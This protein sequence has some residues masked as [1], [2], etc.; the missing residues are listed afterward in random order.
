MFEKS[1]SKI[2]TSDSFFCT[3]IVRGYK[4]LWVFMTFFKIRIQNPSD[5]I[6]FL[7]FPVLRKKYLRSIENRIQF[8][9]R[10]TSKKTILFINH[11]E[12]RTGAPKLLFEIAKF[13]E[14]EYRVI[15]LSLRQG[16]AHEVFKNSF[17][18]IV[19]ACKIFLFPFTL[20]NAKKIISIIDPDL[21]YI[22]SLDSHKYS[23][24]SRE[25]G[26]P[27]IFHIHELEGA[28]E[29]CFQNKK[30][31]VD[32]SQCA[33]E[34]LAV[35]NKVRVFAQNFLKCAPEKVKTIP[36]FISSS[37]VLSKSEEVPL[38]RVYEEI[39][40]K[41]GEIVIVGAGSIHEDKEVRRKGF[42]LMVEAF[43]NLTERG[44]NNFRFLWVGRSK[45]KSV[46]KFLQRI[47]IRKDAFC[48]AGEKGNPYPYL[49]AADVFL[50]PSRED[51]FPLVFLEALA[52]SKPVIAFKEGGG[53]KEAAGPDDII[54]IDAMNSV[55]ISDTIIKLT[56]DRS[57]MKRCSMQG[58]VIQKKFEQEIILPHF[59]DVIETH[60]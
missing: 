28:V 5:I 23:R 17:E 46:K 50:L 22:N 19:Y 9:G 7:F 14:K 38:Q 34:F 18:V 53:V 1:K 54:L 31:L 10:D 29:R 4:F 12:T 33:D 41:D 44:Y 32:F 30:D 57:L 58:P 21:V 37:V 40:K 35:S 42:D 48:L 16:S 59:K 51:P 39:E 24:A 8:F 49:R 52:L 2:K 56:S 47:K 15:I 27:A 45:C 26:I 6:F 36:G 13:L 43:I 20:K 25:L 3:S 55:S 60:I 11:E